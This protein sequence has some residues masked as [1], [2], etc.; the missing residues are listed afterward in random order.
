MPPASLVTATSYDWDAEETAMPINF[1]VNQVSK[2]GSQ[3][4]QDGGGALLAPEPGQRPRGL[5]PALKLR[6]AVSAVE[7]PPRS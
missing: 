3:M 2:I 6:V 7:Q 1:Q 5:R 4:V